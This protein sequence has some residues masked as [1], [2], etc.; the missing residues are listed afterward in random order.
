M[1]NEHEIPISAVNNT[2]VMEGDTTNNWWWQ[3]H[4]NQ[5]K[6]LMGSREYASDKNIVLDFEARTKV[7][8]EGGTLKT[9]DNALVF[10][11][12]DALTILLAADTN[13]LNQREQNWTGPHPHQRV[14]QQVE[15]AA[16]R[17]YS[18]L[19]K[20][21][22]SDYQ[23]LYGRLSLD[24]GKSPSDILSM[25]TAERVKIYSEQVKKN[26]PA[27]VDRDLEELL[28]QYA[29]YLMISCSRP[30]HGALPANLQGL[31]LINKRPA[32][33]CDYHTDVNVQMNTFRRHTVSH[34]AA[35]EEQSFS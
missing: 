27:A 26:G 21:H 2:L 16:K 17:P 1:G 30:G 15:A 5:P 3:V 7:L 6:R 35:K 13:Y 32:W 23:S 25:P 22:T 8:N 28:Y 29:R 24:I 4:L 20:E 10:E 18:E 33:R 31:W 19:L 34:R 12:C 9:V 14:L 11:K